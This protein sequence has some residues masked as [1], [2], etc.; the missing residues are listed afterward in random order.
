[1]PTLRHR[2]S[3]RRRCLHNPLRRRLL[4]SALLWL[5]HLRLRKILRYLLRYRRLLLLLLRLRVLR[6]QLFTALHLGKHQIRRD[7]RRVL[8]RLH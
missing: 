8:I 5:S 4:R 1:M 6:P 3:L 2:H 7:S